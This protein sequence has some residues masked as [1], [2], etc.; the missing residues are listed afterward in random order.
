MDEHML[1]LKGDVVVF[2]HDIIDENLNDL[3][4]WTS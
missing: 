3:T 2:D 4:W 1:L